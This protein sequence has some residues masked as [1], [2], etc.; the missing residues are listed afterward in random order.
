MNNDKK[1]TPLKQ[2]IEEILDIANCVRKL[3]NNP[4]DPESL[5]EDNK[6]YVKALMLAIEDM[7]LDVIITNLLLINDEEPGSIANEKDEVSPEISS[8][9]EYHMS[10]KKTI[11]DAKEEYRK[12]KYKK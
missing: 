12:E 4:P 11:K 6:L 9:V 1:Q 8:L 5:S 2:I 10:L 7:L 3:K